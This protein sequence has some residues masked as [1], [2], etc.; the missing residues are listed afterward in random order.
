MDWCLKKYPVGKIAFF[1][2]ARL[3]DLKVSV[4]F[5]Y[6]SIR[7]HIDDLFMIKTVKV[8]ADKGNC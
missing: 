1:S 4:T 8:G 3:A 7:L 6:L 5:L 2:K